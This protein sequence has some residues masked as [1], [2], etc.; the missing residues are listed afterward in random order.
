MPSAGRILSIGGGKG[1]VGKSVVAG[2]LSV[3]LAQE[4][5]RVVL[6]DADLG[7]ANQHT[8]FGVARPGPGLQGFLDGSLPDLDAAAVETGVENLRLVPG[9]AGVIGAANIPAARRDKLLRHVRALQADVVVVD[10]GAGV[11]FNVLDLFDVADLRLVVLTPQLTSAQNAY[12]FLKGAVFR[13]LRRLAA[14][15]GKAV[16]VDASEEAQEATA[17]TPALLD[18]LRIAE[19]ALV[20][21][22]QAGLS[23]FGARLVG[24][25]VFEPREKNVLYA[26]SRMVRDFLGVDA[27]V[28]GALRASRRAHDSVNLG[29]PFLLDARG[30]ESAVAL[31]EMA[32]ALLATPLPRRADSL[33][34]PAPSPP[35]P[36]PPEGV[37]L[38]V[39]VSRYHRAVE[40]VPL[41]CP[42]TLVAPGGLCPV[43]LRD[44][45]LGG[46]LLEGD[47]LPA[48][49]TRAVLVLASLDARPSLPCAVR[50]ANPQARRAGVE[51]VTD[52]DVAARV[53][54]ELVRRYRSASPGS[55][56]ERPD[57]TRRT[58]AGEEGAD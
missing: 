42:A 23:T 25:Q 58:A 29:R 53:V 3:A 5:L 50:H 52:R 7:A 46:A 4:G 12:A 56:Q 6:V 13:E 41:D 45:S 28:L 55:P 49:G 20:E 40:R 54:E 37:P 15:E 22:L 21:R 31:R 19:P 17:S 2:N 35:G 10:V 44:V 1:G 34:P 36:P 27:P 9:T 26:I 51:F 48:P 32:A 16:L 14:L 18:K 33:A 39:A 8:L 43:R 57:H 30:E 47:R 38:P 11:S 24:N